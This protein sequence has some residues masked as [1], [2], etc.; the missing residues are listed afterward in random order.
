MDDRSLN[1]DLAGGNGRNRRLWSH[2]IL[3]A[4]VLT[5]MAISLIGLAW[6]SGSGRSSPPTTMTHKG[7][8]LGQ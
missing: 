8:V 3:F 4:T 6:V 7:V 1:D 2:D 5:L